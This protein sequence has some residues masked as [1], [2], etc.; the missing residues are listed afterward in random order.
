VPQDV[1]TLFVH[2]RSIAA[3]GAGAILAA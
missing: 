3:D 2:G 1:G